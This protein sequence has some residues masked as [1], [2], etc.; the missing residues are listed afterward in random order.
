MEIVF[1]GNTKKGKEILIRYPETGDVEEMLRYINELSKEK[2]FIRYQG[3]QETLE[4]ETK[5]LNS[6]LEAI[7]NGK[8]VNL[9]TFFNGRLI[10][11]SDIKMKDKTEK[12]IGSLGITVAKDFR[13]EGLGNLLMDLTLKEAKEKLLNIK[14]VTLEVYS[15]NDIA[16]NLYKK[17]GFKKYGMLPNGVSRDGKFEDDF[18]MYKN[19]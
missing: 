4:S 1:Q 15:A 7:K 10:G 17:F 16:R 18:L 5:Y 12:H 13:G 14:I 6:R 3:E 19:I 2:T 11:S 9:L 8:V